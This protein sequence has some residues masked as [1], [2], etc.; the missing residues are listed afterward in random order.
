MTRAQRYAVIRKTRGLT[1]VSPTAM[2]ETKGPLN[3]L[4]VEDGAR[5]KRSFHRP[6]SNCGVAINSVCEALMVLINKRPKCLR[7]VVCRN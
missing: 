3:C 5:S 4:S 6:E 7:R 2:L 1:I